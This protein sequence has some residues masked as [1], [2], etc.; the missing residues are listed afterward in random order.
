MLQIV[1]FQ[2]DKMADGNELNDNSWMHIT[3]YNNMH[4]TI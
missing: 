3:K 1:Y 4:I 2:F